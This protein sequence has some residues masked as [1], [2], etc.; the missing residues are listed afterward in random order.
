MKLKITPEICCEQCNEIIHNH[1]DCP[2]CGK[3][4]SASDEYYKLDIYDKQVT[5]SCRNCKIQYK[6]VEG[7]PYDEEA[8]WIIKETENG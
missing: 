2:N 3:Q 6:L 7:K 1:F 5:I 4:Y 8:E